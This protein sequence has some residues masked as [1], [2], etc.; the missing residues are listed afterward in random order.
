MGPECKAILYADAVGTILDRSCLPL[1][2]QHL[3]RLSQRAFQLL[4][5]P[6][7]LPPVPTLRHPAQY[8]FVQRVRRRGYRRQPQDALLNP[9]LIGIGGTVEGGTS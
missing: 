8:V 2:P 6:H 3:R 4:P 5:H 9:S 1:F 7:L